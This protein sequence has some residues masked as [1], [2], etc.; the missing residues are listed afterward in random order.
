MS[1]GQ[2]EEGLGESS[3]LPKISER[4]RGQR[5]D[6]TSSTRAASLEAAI[7]DNLALE[8]YLESTAA[9][10]TA[11]Q[12]LK[13]LLSI[14]SVVSTA[15]SF[16]KRQQAAVGVTS[17][18]FREIGTGS[19]GKVFEHPESIRVYK[20]PLTDN[21]SKLWNNYVMN[22]RI[23]DSFDQLG[24]LAGQVE[25]PRAAWY[26]QAST[27]EFWDANIDRFPFTDV[28]PRQRRDVL[29]IERILPLPKP[30][31]DRLVDLYCF[32][33]GRESAKENAANRD[34][35]VRP[36]LGRIRQSS[37]SRLKSFRFGTS[38]YTLTR[39]KRLA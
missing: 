24:P 17:A 6:A 3:R 1:A 15:S 10:Q 22:R 8:D 19:I 2:H 27:A 4:R 36:L 39:L 37:A 29:C 26:A 23:E 5:W 20:L 16:A 38:N 7:R 28:F 9:G 34:C 11:E 30:T 18:V 25:I 21:N 35:L 32:E 12:S 33:K 31:R 13:R 14:R